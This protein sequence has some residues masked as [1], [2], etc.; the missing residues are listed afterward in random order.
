MRSQ[1]VARNRPQSRK[2][3]RPERGPRSIVRAANRCAVAALRTALCRRPEIAALLLGAVLNACEQDNSDLPLRP[4]VEDGDSKRGENLILSYGCG[5]CHQVPGID[6]AEGV[7]G[8]PLSQFS[9]RVYVAGM[10]RNT[11]DNLIAW[12]KNPQA[13]VPGNAMPNLGVSDR[14]A[15]DMASYLYTI[16]E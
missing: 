13:I 2:T 14:D 12:L 4:R 16:K 10:L 8:P 7:V 11:P 15:R 5:S 1:G 3:A 6:Q 9:R